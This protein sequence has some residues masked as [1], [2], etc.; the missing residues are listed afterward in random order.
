M[1]FTHAERESIPVRQNDGPEDR[2]NTR[3]RRAL[4]RRHSLPVFI[5]LFGLLAA[6]SFGWTSGAS[7]RPYNWSPGPTPNSG[8]PTGDDVPDPSPKPK[9]LSSV[10]SPGAHAQGNQVMAGVR[11]VGT[12]QWLVRYLNVYLLR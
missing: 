8:D 2:R 5:A 6:A 10:F 11:L 9:N 3:M 12:W 1:G 4:R 7:A